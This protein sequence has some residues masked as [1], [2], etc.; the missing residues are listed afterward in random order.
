MPKITGKI[1]LYLST[2]PLR[3]FKTDL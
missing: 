2:G 1:M 3:G